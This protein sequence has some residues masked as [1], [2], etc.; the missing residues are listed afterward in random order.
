[1]VL[2][3]EAIFDEIGSNHDHFLARIEDGLEQRVDRAAGSDGHHDLFRDEGQLVVAGE[4]V[5][6][7]LAG[8][9][10]TDVFH[11]L[12]QPWSLVGDQARNGFVELG[13][14]LQ[15]R[16]ADREIVDR[17]LAVLEH[18]LALFEELADPGGLL[19]IGVDSLRD[20]HDHLP[21]VPT[22]RPLRRGRSRPIAA[23][24][25]LSLPIW[26]VLV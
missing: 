21:A 12:V 3:V 8:R 24:P 7:G 4:G 22:N 15:V 10:E 25:P 9:E 6:D 1:V 13:R 17:T 5:G 11:V 2:D 16:V 19:E 14:G 20:R 23:L 18:Q 26:Q